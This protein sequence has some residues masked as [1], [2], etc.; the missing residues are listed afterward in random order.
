MTNSLGYIQP[1]PWAGSPHHRPGHRTSMASHHMGFSTSFLT[2]SDKEPIIHSPEGCSD[3]FHCVPYRL[4][5]AQ[6]MRTSFCCLPF[7]SCYP[8]PPCSLPLLHNLLTLCTMPLTHSAA[9]LVKAANH[10]PPILPAAS[11]LVFFITYHIL[12]GKKL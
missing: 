10:L 3:S 5:S 2:L 1:Q 6:L 7:P 12:W 9:V 8:S 11:D 4:T